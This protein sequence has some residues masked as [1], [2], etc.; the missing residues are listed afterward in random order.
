MFPVRELSKILMKI[1]AIF[2]CPPT[3]QELDL[4]VESVRQLLGRNVGFRIEGFPKMILTQVVNS[5]FSI[6]CRVLITK[7]T[8]LCRSSCE[9]LSSKAKE[10]ES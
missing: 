6:Q 9:G 3:E 8:A 10:G 4:V 5:L 1:G 2:N 7:E